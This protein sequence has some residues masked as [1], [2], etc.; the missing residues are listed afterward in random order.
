MAGQKNINIV[1][2]ID[3]QQ[4]QV[5]KT[6]VDQAKVA[7]DQLT[8]STKNLSDQ[9][10]T[11]AKRFGDNIETLRV[12]MQQLKAQIDLTSQSDTTTLN[13]RIALYKEMQAQMDKYNSGLKETQVQTQNV[14]TNLNTLYGTI[15]TVITAGLLKEL[16][17]VNLE[18]ARLSGQ[19]EG[20]TRGFQRNIPGASLLLTQLREKTHG[21]LTD[22]ELMQRTLL[23]KNL[24][25]SV[26]ELGTI[27][28]FVQTRVQQTGQNF[29]VLLD[30]FIRG[31]G[32]KSPR[33]LDDLGI[34]SVRL[35][36]NLDGVALSAIS[37]GDFTQK[38][39]KIAQEELAKMGGYVETSATKVDQLGVSFQGLKIIISQTFNSTGMISFFDGAIKGATLFVKAWGQ[40]SSFAGFLAAKKSIEEMDGATREATK[41]VDNFTKSNDLDSQSIDKQIESINRQIKA[42]EDL[43]TSNKKIHQPGDFLG[44]FDR[45]TFSE[46][47]L[48]LTKF[49]NSSLK[50]QIDLL[51]QYKDQLKSNDG[52][53]KEQKGYLDQVD[54]QIKQLNE[55]LKN[56]RQDQS[57]K[58]VEIQIQIKQLESNKADFL[59]P[60]R[61]ARQTKA[62][63]DKTN[64]AIEEGIRSNSETILK[65]VSKASYSLEDNSLFKQLNK[66][67]MKDIHMFVD[68]LKD[69]MKEADQ[70]I[71]DQE[72]RTQRL[73][74]FLGQQ[75]Y[76]NARQVANILIQNDVQKYDTQIQA[77][78]DYYSNQ[79][80]LAGTNSKRIAQLQKEEAQ[81]QKQL[82]NERTKAQKRA[83]I[84]RV[85]IDTAANVIRSILENGGIPWGLPFGGIAAAMGL[86]QIVAINGFAKGVIDLKGPGSETSDSI[87]SLL[88]RGE[89]VMTAEE[90]RNSGNILR[91][92]R[93]KKLNDQIL[94]KL[95]I[96]TD[97]IQANFD[98]SR[99]VSELK[100]GRQPDLIKRFGVIYEAKEESKNMRR[101]I[102][103][104]S[105]T[106]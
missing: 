19:V 18:M 105:F 5:A 51:S 91:N 41:A 99:I 38:V 96:T 20:V 95:T 73:L 36:E 74:H 103:S 13:Q 76:T 59:D 101:I 93:A 26:S 71:A 46:K 81:K 88:S 53:Q 83:N 89:S 79:E 42:N 62:S 29:D 97:G 55:D 43:I 7:T 27:F 94:D 10:A 28:E 14:G 47:E 104:K 86:A 2:N 70:A 30:K 3:T 34:S 50:I 54:N 17:T 65:S 90:T 15:R 12:Q 35:K 64:D 48:E 63:F 106:G 1:Y 102:R 100:K 80:A 78:Q 44:L 52:P 23:A 22:F 85:E 39:S 92:I 21:V 45:Q 69:G 68:G 61:M 8:Q 77:L 6:V 82:E 16:V 60:D 49:Q 24:G 72:R 66:N 57:G 9:G 75:I 33:L 84:R 87:P 11:N 67:M 25:V 37:I 32:V 58:A 40:S 56:L 31:I 4:I 98:D